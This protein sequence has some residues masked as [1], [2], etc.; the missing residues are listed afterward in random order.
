MPVKALIFGETLTN[1]W[2]TDVTMSTKKFKECEE[3][4]FQHNLLDSSGNTRAAW[5][6]LI[7]TFCHIKKAIII[8]RT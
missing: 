7:T 6:V 2:Q 3:S 8:F 1:L 4:I 5:Q